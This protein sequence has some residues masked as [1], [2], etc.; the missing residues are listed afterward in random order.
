[1]RR[2]F[3]E[4]NTT[5]IIYITHSLTHSWSWALLEK[6]LIVQP[7]K[8]FPAFYGTQRFITAFTR[9][10]HLSLSWARSIQ[11][12]PSHSISK[13]TYVKWLYYVAAKFIQHRFFGANT[14]NLLEVSREKLI[15]SN[16]FEI[17]LSLSFES[18]QL[19]ATV[20]NITGCPVVP[21]SPCGRFQIFRYRTEWGGTEHN[22]K[23]CS[24]S[25]LKFFA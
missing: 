10:L 20:S 21:S 1:M 3:K 23:I 25:D 13:E 14:A 24:G 8:N 22:F 9:A 4:K 16:A 12:L 11:S 15:E 19:Y 17:F 2:Q 7:L 18:S 5:E 6:L